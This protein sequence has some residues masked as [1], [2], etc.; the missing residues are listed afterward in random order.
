M[1]LYEYVCLDCGFRFDTLRPMKNAD[2][3]IACSQCESQHTSRLL[4][5][6]YAQSSGREVTGSNSGACASCS[7]NSCA[8]C[9][10][11]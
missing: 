11:R 1:P 5:L 4:S 2:A 8:S 9:G 6:F 7:S 10:S 3:P